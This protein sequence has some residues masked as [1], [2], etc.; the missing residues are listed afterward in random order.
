MNNLTDK[1][2]EF[3]CDAQSADEDEHLFDIVDC[4]LVNLNDFTQGTAPA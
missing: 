3:L 1:Q 2:I 4:N